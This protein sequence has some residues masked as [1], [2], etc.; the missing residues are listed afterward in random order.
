M[1]LL[2]QM[3]WIMG[4]STIIRYV[5]YFTTALRAVHPIELEVKSLD[6][7]KQL[8][9]ALAQHA[10]ALSI[11]VKQKENGLKLLYFQQALLIRSSALLFAKALHTLL[12]SISRKQTGL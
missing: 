10:E 4:G 12:K 8:K 1:L 5:A 2:P 6:G 11:G 7:L 3:S 9:V